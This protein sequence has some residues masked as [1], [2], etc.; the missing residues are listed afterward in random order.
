VVEHEPLPVLLPRRTVLGSALAGSALALAGGWGSSAE[1]RAARSGLARS[2]W[3]RQRGR[4][5]TMSL[6]GTS[7][8]VTL[9]SVDDL[10]GASSGAPGRFSLVFRTATLDVPDGIA[11][12]RRRRFPAAD[13]FVTQVDRGVEARHYQAVVNRI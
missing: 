7:A 13:L 4:R 1:A 5:F 12:L 10:S 3:A 8:A 2:T 6:G 9:V 11:R